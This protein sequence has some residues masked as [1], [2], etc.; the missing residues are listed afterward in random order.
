[1]PEFCLSSKYLENLRKTVERFPEFRERMCTIRI[2]ESLVIEVPVVVAASFSATITSIVGS[3]PTTATFSFTLRAK[4]NSSLDKIKR[5]LQHN[6]SVTL[7]NDEDIRAFAE[8]GL[9]IGNDDFAAPLRA[10]LSEE[11]S[12][13]REDNVVRIISTKRTF[14]VEDST[15]ECSFI[16]SNFESMSQREDFVAFAKDAGNRG[17]VRGILGSPDLRMESED[18]LLAFILRINEGASEENVT[19]DLFEFIF[20]EYCSAAKCDEF[21]RFACSVFRQQSVKSLLTCIG[22]R[23]A[24]PSIPMKPDTIEGRHKSQ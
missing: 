2:N 24:Q 21:I 14:R 19:S 22:R 15:K 9:C 4:S 17:I 10:Q 5:V 7:D 3:D 1:M 16:A 18:T 20:I 11:S 13:I 12:D 8:F 23:F 6:E